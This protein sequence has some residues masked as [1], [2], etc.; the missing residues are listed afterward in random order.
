MTPGQYLVLVIE[1]DYFGIQ[2]ATTPYAGEFVKPVSGTNPRTYDNGDFV[3]DKW[4]F[5]LFVTDWMKPIVK[6]SKSQ[7]ELG[8]LYR[9]DNARA[10]GLS[11]FLNQDFIQPT[12]RSLNLVLGRP[13]GKIIGLGA[14]GNMSAMVGSIM[15]YNGASNAYYTNDLS[16]QLFYFDEG[17]AIEFN[18]GDSDKG[19]Y[20]G[21][22]IIKEV[23]DFEEIID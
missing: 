2:Y 4:S 14:V 22:H 10:Y 5:T 15:T 6:F 9:I 23:I 13:S 18:P 20:S 3:I 16:K 7:F 1:E 11:E 17:Q 19:R 8:T 21:Y 12:V